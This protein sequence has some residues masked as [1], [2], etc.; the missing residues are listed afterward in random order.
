M[1][2]AIDLNADVNAA[3]TVTAATPLY[4]AAQQG[5]VDAV[6]L[7]LARGAQVDASNRNGMTALTA[8]VKSTPVNQKCR[9]CVAKLLAVG[10]DPNLATDN[11]DTALLSA[12]RA[13]D[14]AY[15]VRTLD[16]GYAPLS[17]LVCGVAGHVSERAPCG[18]EAAYIV[19]MCHGVL[20]VARSVS[21]ASE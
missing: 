10:A 9:D 8:A 6:E 4:V 12:C 5:H 20:Q 1:A 17:L 2:R 19:R 11:G 15:I 3:D 18:C 21:A 14:A 16:S 7:A 13:R